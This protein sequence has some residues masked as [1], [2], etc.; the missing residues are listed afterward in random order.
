[1]WKYCIIWGEILLHI[2]V[3][4][5][6]AK[7]DSQQEVLQTLNTS[8]KSLFLDVLTQKSNEMQG[9]LRSMEKCK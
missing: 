2:F 9:C 3:H 5:Y 4:F 7:T 6:S 8:L 1:M